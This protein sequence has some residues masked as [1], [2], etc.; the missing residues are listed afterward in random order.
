MERTTINKAGKQPSKINAGMI[1]NLAPYIGL[2]LVTIVFS[3]T[4][5]GALISAMNLQSL[6][7]EVIVTAL[8][9]VGAVFIFGAGYFDM[10]MAG[11]VCFSAVIGGM[12]MINTGSVP[13]GALVILAVSLAFGLI[14]GLFAAFINVPF[15]I[16]TIVLGTV[17][18]SVVLVLMGSESTIYLKNAVSEIPS[19]TFAQMSIINIV[20]LAAFFLFC[21]VLFNYTSLGIRI[22]SIGGNKISATQSGIAIK[23]TTIITFL[24][25]AVGVAL[26]AFII[27]IRTRTVGGTTASSVG[28]D[29]LVAL[30]LG[31][32]PLTGGP[33]SKISA[34]L[35]GAVTITVLNSGLTI[36]GL[37]TGQ[38]QICRGVVFILVVLVASLSYRGKLL[39]R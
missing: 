16:F 38:I 11:V 32:M 4:T 33:R 2:L 36:M 18:T 28:T 23:R 20:A 19:P 31:G 5:E 7:N 37:S 25:S 34:G 30:V 15:F 10:S 14:K 9:T 3:I 22:K 24:V 29:V 26:A 12:V 8:V 6:T 39:P 21:L 27:L 1:G 35:V 17:I 13:A